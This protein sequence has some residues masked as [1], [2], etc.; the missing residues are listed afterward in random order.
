MGTEAHSL[1]RWV[2]KNLSHPGW[3]DNGVRGRKSE[4]KNYKKGILVK[5]K[6]TKWDVRKYLGKL[7]VVCLLMSFP[8]NFQTESGGSDTSNHSKTRCRT[9]NRKRWERYWWTRETSLL[10]I[11][12]RSG[13]RYGK[14]RH[15][16]GNILQPRKHFGHCLGF[17]QSGRYRKHDRKIKNK[18]S[19]KKQLWK[20]VELKY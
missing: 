19:C 9:N 12:V 17:A 1:R 3:E 16:A 20:W 18:K 11:A 6:S 14:R 8:K 7:I 5:S 15:A 10:Q 2:P 4:H 13:R